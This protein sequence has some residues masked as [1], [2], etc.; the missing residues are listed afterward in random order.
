MFLVYRAFPQ[1]IQQEE[2]KDEY[3]DNAFSFAH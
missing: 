2:V 1:N 3:D